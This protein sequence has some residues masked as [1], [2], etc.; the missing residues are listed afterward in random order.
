MPRFDA[1]APGC[2]RWL[3][4]RDPETDRP[5]ETAVAVDTDEGWMELYEVDRPRHL[6]TVR[7]AGGGYAPAPPARVYR[8]FDLYDKRTGTLLYRVRPGAKHLPR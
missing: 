7:L 8:P 3:Q 6:R 2:P 1:R 4:P 5:I